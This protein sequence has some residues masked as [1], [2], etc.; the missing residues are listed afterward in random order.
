MVVTAEAEDESGELPQKEFEVQLH[1]E[2]RRILKNN[3][4]QEVF[5]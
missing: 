1:E 4:N 2:V 5:K 3:K